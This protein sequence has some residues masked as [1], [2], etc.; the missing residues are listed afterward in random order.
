MSKI[1]VEYFVQ[2]FCL[3]AGEILKLSLQNFYKYQGHIYIRSLYFPRSGDPLITLD[4][5]FHCLVIINLAFVLFRVHSNQFSCEQLRGGSKQILRH[6]EHTT[7]RF[8][9]FYVHYL[10][11][12]N[13][14][15]G[16][17]DILYMLQYRGNMSS[18]FSVNLGAHRQFLFLT[19]AHNSKATNSG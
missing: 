4:L 1:F 17:V 7:N 9:L 11:L 19:Y 14:Q 10:F 2:N 5:V 18:I 16:M 8:I 6:Y 15:C 3:S 13:T 12:C